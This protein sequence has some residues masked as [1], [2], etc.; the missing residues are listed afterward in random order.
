MKH[1]VRDSQIEE[2]VK[3]INTVLSV[4]TYEYSKN[5]N[6]YQLVKIGE[7]RSE[8]KVIMADSK[9]DLLEKINVFLT[10]V[11]ETKESYGLPR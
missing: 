3:T 8:T 7:G 9:R 10:A 1:Q 11:M 6:S 2:R 5:L 4:N